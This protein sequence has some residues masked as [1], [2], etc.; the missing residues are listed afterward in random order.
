VSATAELTAQLQH[1]VRMLEDDLR[2]RVESQPHVLAAWQAEHKEAI[3]RERTAAAWSTWRDDRVTQAA[4]AWALATVFV[5]FCE[6]NRLVR[7]VWIGGPLKRRQEA[8]DAQ[9]AYFRAHP[10]DTDREWIEQAIAHLRSLPATRGLVD[11]HAVLR[12]VTPSGDAASALLEFWRETDEAG[13]LLRDLSD[14]DISTRFLGDLYQDISPSARD[15]YALLQTPEFVEEFILDR[16][17]TPALDERQLDGFRV[18]DP[19]CGS[20]HFLLGAFA[21]LLDRWQREAPGMERQA[22]VQQALDAVHGV[23][24]NPFAVAIARFRLTLAAMRTSGLHDL[25]DAPA[26]KIHL[27]AGD[28]LLHGAGQQTLSGDADVHDFG[29]ET[30]DLDALHEILEPGRY[31]VVV[32]NP[33]Y[34]TA[35]DKALNAGYRLRYATCKGTY[36]LTVPFM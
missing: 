4:V 5:R 3:A 36:A 2:A 7:P 33:P 16:T 8:L 35:K 17:L 14:P 28:S 11:E 29:Y 15:T 34:I 31:D 20:G 12:L 18:I 9:L 10:E 24:L 19:T 6:D 30:E 25:E 23:D 13:R 1:Q 32:G 26:F 22:L 27:A 21:R